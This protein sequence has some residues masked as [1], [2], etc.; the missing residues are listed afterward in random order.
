MRYAI[1]WDIATC[2][3]IKISVFILVK[4]LTAF[5]FVNGVMSLAIEITDSG[6]L[7]GPFVQKTKFVANHTNCRKLTYLVLYKENK[8]V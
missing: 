8:I 6:F 2:N 5:R 4:I 1:S 7:H 3:Q